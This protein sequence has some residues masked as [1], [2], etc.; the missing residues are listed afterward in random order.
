ME[1]DGNLS[2]TNLLIKASM[3]RALLSLAWFTGLSPENASAFKEIISADCQSGFKQQWIKHHE[4][5]DFLLLVL[6]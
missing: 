3:H 5:K 4:R 2:T 1:Q 6:S